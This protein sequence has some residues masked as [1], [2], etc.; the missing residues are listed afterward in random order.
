MLVV[1]AHMLVVM[2]HMLVSLLLWHIC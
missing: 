1:M 2:A